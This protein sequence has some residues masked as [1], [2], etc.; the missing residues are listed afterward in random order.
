MSKTNQTRHIK[1]HVICKCKSRLYV[2]VS[3]NKQRWNNDKCRCT[4][5]K[6]KE[7]VDKGMCDKGFIWNTSNSDSGCNK[8]YDVGEYLHYK[9]CKFLIISW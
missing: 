7:L 4:W 1:W 6:C 8:W 3:N 9:N 5:Y 2:R